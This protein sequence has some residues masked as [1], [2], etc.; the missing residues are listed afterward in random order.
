MTLAL[1]YILPILIGW[2]LDLILG[3]PAFLP[4]PVV[5]FGKAI[6]FFEKRLNKGNNRVLKGALTA[7]MARE[8]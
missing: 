5:W 6:A 7:V 1:L 2:S 3:D 8:K 4:H